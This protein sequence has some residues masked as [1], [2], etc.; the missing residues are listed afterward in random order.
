MQDSYQK[1]VQVITRVM[2][3]I[4]T[5]YSCVIGHT[6]LSEVANVDAC[7]ILCKKTQWS[8]SFIVCPIVWKQTKYTLVPVSSVYDGTYSHSFYIAKQDAVRL[9]CKF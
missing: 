2:R 1:N 6:N 8:I 7:W 3:F 4:K 5:K 9:V